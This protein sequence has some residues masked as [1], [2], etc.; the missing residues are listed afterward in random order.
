MKA[1]SLAFIFLLLLTPVALADAINIGVN[2]T[3]TTTTIPPVP[4]AHFIMGM[5][6]LVAGAGTIIFA[7]EALLF[8]PKDW[9]ELLQVFIAIIIIVVVLGL[10]FTNPPPF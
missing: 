4:P 5:T 9:K 3:P 8:S 7:I 10:F 6:G 2:V 1:I